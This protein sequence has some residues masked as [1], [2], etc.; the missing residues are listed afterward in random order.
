MP[1]KD[2]SDYI[3]DELRVGGELYSQTF[4]LER[5]GT[6]FQGRLD[7]YHRRLLVDHLEP[8]SSQVDI[9]PLRELAEEREL[10]KLLV[11]C[12]DHL[13]SKL[14]AQGF[15]QEANF[16][17]YYLR[18]DADL[19]SLFLDP[20]R[21]SSPT[22]RKEQAMLRRFYQG[23]P[24]PAELPGGFTMRRAGPGDLEAIMEIYRAVYQ[25]SPVPELEE[26]YISRLLA[27]NSTPFAIGF[28]G[29]RPVS[30]LAV[31]IDFDH[32][33]GQMTHGA[34][35]P[36][37]RGRGLAQALIGLLEGI[38]RELELNSVYG[39]IPARDPGS[40][41][42]LFNREYRFTGTL[43]NDYR[44]PEGNFINM[45]LWIKLFPTSRPELE[46]EDYG[47]DY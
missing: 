13:T 19:L 22:L 21:E 35:L 32:Q 38:C 23:R 34:T 27:S 8:A 43:V 17:R 5:R 15:R 1:E 30:V 36:D 37:Y 41:K 40:N 33:T 3:P 10:S 7:F 4:R 46:E 11:V 29:E 44:D 28:E 26:G 12:P 2:Y 24:R 42:A 14:L 39:F 9:S 47:Y 18:E 6:T 45:N 16:P 25:D 31:Q 20:E